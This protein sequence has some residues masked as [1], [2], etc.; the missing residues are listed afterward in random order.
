MHEDDMK[1]ILSMVRDWL[2]CDNWNERDCR[3]EKL[4]KLCGNPLYQ[5]V[6]LED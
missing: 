1:D 5:D 4:L 3:Y 2:L 6:K